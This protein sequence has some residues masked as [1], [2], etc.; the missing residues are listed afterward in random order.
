[1]DIIKLK[2]ILIPTALIICCAVL[3]APITASAIGPVQ[4]GA[5]ANNSNSNGNTNTN[6]NSNTQLNRNTGIT[7]VPDYDKPVQTNSGKGEFGN[8]LTL[9]TL[10]EII[11]R[12]IRVLLALVGMVSIVVIILAGFR[13]VTQGDNPTAVGKAKNAITWAIVGLITALLSFSI[14]SIIQRIIQR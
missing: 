4:T 9:K 13:M 10:P 12:I 2:N 6:S 8:P 11:A 14:V 7:N 5:N 1:M 3:I